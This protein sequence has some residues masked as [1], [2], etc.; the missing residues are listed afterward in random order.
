MSSSQK[1][2]KVILVASGDSR[3]PANQQCWDAQQNMESLLGA[4]FEKFGVK[5][6][7]AHQ[8][9]PTLG[10]GFIDSQKMGLDV[11]RN[12][13]PD[14]PLVV[15]ENVWQ[16]SHHVLPGMTTHRAPI[17][18]VANWDGTW[19]G[20]VGMLNLNG[21]LTK[22]G[23]KYSTLWSENFDDEFF[24]NK[25]EE[26][27][28]TG[29]IAHDKS[30]VRSYE[31]VNIPFE[32]RSAGAAFAKKFRADKAIMGVFDE[33]CMGM[34]NAILPDHLLHATGLFKE[35][36]SQSALY[37]AMLQVTNEEAE[38]VFDWLLNQGMAFDWGTNPATELTR[39][40]TLE[41]CKMYIAAGRMADDFGCST[42]GIQYQ[43]GLKELTAVSDLAEGLLN[44]THRPPIYNKTGSELFAGRAIPHFNEVDECAGLDGLLTYQLWQELGMEGDNTLHDIRW[45]EHY[46]GDGIDEFVWVFMISGAVPASHL[47]G[48][49]KGAKSMRQPPMFFP[50][51][52]GT[53]RGVSKAG[54]LVWSRVYVKDNAVHCDLGIGKAVELPEEETNRRWAKTNMQWPMMHGV[55][56][57][58]TRD[59]LMAQHQSN[60]IHVVYATNKEAAIKACFTKAAAFNELGL[61][62][63][64]CGD[65]Q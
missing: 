56:S 20:L 51:G 38:E 39:E 14:T 62:V 49:Y 55:L 11:F 2:N 10:H 42:I 18:T 7:R 36:L 26:W 48:G 45:G 59:Q 46:K 3:L 1:I 53:L 9:N 43:Q 58:V 4:A 16:Y 65:L 33:G 34:Y 60:H 29:D 12:I 52:G 41:Q 57:G 32:L 35:R 22:A 37:A 54:D 63:H 15:A 47:K 50:K 24:L 8:Y 31:Q 6:E 28:F 5:V 25:L 21:S 23:V 27:L 44:A 40:Q 30:H 17:L 19:P 64:F 61:Q 13:D